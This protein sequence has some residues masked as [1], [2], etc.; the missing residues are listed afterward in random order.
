MAKGSVRKR[1][2]KWYYRFCMEDASGRLIQKEFAGTES[3]SETE[4]LMRKAMDDYENKKFIVTAENITLAELLDNWAEED[5][6]TGTLSNGTVLTYTFCIK[7]IKKHPISNMKLK[8][9]SAEQLQLFFDLIAFG[10]REGNFDAGKGY[11]NSYIN[12]YSAIMKRVFKF[13]VFPKK[14]ITI[15]P[16]QYVVIHFKQ[17]TSELFV[18]EMDESATPLTPEM[19]EMLLAYLN[20]HRPDVVLAVQISYYTGLR[21]GEV[22]GLTWQDINLEEQYL[23][24]RRSVSRNAMRHKTEIGT[25]KRAKVRTVDF[26]D[27]LTKILKD[28]KKQQTLLEKAYGELYQRNFYKEVHEKNRTYFECYSLDGTQEVPEDY[29]AID[30]VCRCKDGR[31]LVPTAIKEACKYAAKKV[32]MLEGF[33]FHVLRHTFTTNLLRSGAAVKDVQEML[34]HEKVSTTMN[35][36]AHGNRESKKASAKLL[37][38]LAS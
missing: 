27:K 21:V 35:V 19:F 25:T 37:D 17:D 13:A 32:Q 1:G 30:M 14:F 15:N 11:G 28:A 12:I 18:S 9:I 7:Q 24:V 29:N 33:H 6:K 10:G 23:I 8:E 5:L 20:E 3:K 22:S 38:N 16:M 34:G 31:L 26:G 2:K 4:K 36:Y